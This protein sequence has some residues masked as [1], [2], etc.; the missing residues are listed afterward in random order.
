MTWFGDAVSGDFGASTMTLQH[1]S[2]SAIALFFQNPLL[3]F[4][5]ISVGVHPP[6]AHPQHLKVLRHLHIYAMVGG[7]SLWDLEPQP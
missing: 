4:R 2:D 3:T 5:G 6:Y 7:C 1:H